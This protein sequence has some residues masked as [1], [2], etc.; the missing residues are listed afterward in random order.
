MRARILI[1]CLFL[2]AATPA[3][4]E[5]VRLADRLPP[6]TLLYVRLA[7]VGEIWDGFKTL[8]FFQA[9][10]DE[11]VQEFLEASS[12]EM[13]KALAGATGGQGLLERIAALPT[14]LTGETA[15]AILRPDEDTGWV[16][17]LGVAGGMEGARKTARE[18]VDPMLATVSFGE[19]TR[20]IL[21][22]VAIRSFHGPA[23]T[24]DVAVMDGRIVIAS[25]EGVLRGVLGTPPKT[26]LSA[27]PAFEAARKNVGPD[28]AAGFLYFAVGDARRKVTD[29]DRDRKQ[30]EIAGLAGLETIAA[31]LRMEKGRAHETVWLGF[32]EGPRGFF[33]A[34]PGARVDLD[35]AR[36][37]P[38]T[39]FTFFA[40]SV[41]PSEIYRV[42]DEL[43]GTTKS[44]LLGDVGELRG[45]LEKG[46]GASGLAELVGC[47]GTELTGFVALP[48]GGGPIPEVAV[49]VEVLQP[50]KLQTGLVALV[51]T[52][53]GDE[54]KVIR[55]RNREIRYVSVE[56]GGFVGLPLTPCWCVTDGYLIVSHHPTVLKSLIRRLDGSGKSLADDE[57][58]VAA[59]ERLPEGAVAAGYINTQRLFRYL[60]GLMLPFLSAMGDDLPFDPGALPS[61]DAIAQ[62]LSFALSA[63]T[64]AD[65][66]LTVRTESDG[67]GPVSLGAYGLIAAAVIDD[68]WWT[69]DASLRRGDRCGG[70]M[71]TLHEMIEEY[72]Q[73]RGHY[74]SKLDDLLDEDDWRSHYARCPAAE[75]TPED[76][77][78]RRHWEDFGYRFRG[79]EK[80]PA[81]LPGGAMLMWDSEPRHNGGR[82]VLFADGEVTWMREPVFAARRAE[83]AEK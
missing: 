37:A 34:F 19:P 12:E 65:D 67:Y 4:A 1:V 33:G 75:R 5:E 15:F 17:S 51:R 79:V 55:Y 71:T 27:H 50:D 23:R 62:H 45:S 7:P 59:G 49:A 69:K 54:P 36:L 35:A 31:G 29:S 52:G 11:E 28:G 42:I 9:W 48:R 66:G 6:S 16:I 80:P 73:T 70:R 14:T 38:A 82:I 2:L 63:L 3:V 61:A 25:G 46:L 8:P 24:L 22:G 20:S 78:R 68:A 58:F 77:R 83:E 43:S 21:E 41:K 40:A 56:T 76:E 39:A 64:R 10:R 47:L 57:A 74:P 32:P 30:M 60:Y 81:N 26:P 53:T 72:R 18:L 44:G 13:E